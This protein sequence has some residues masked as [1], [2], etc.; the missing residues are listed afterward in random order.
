M[1]TIRDL[2]EV[3]DNITSAIDRYE[4][5]KIGDTHTQSEIAKSLSTNLHFLVQFKIESHDAWMSTWFN[6]K[7]CRK[8]KGS[9][10]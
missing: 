7:G 1:S 5:C 2:N 9:G 4:T 3:L 6:S 8:R 10:F